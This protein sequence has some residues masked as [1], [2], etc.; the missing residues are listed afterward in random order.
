MY[1]QSAVKAYQDAGNHAGSAR[2]REAAL[3]IK[4]AANLQKAK[5]EK[6]TRED[7]DYALEFNRKIWTF[8]VG[9]LLD[10]NHE[11]PKEIRE[12]IVNL[13]IFTFNQTVK[14]M[15]EPR[16]DGVDALININRNIAEGLRAKV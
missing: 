2:D 6:S 12:N 10:E 16:N 1:N 15:S 5:S 11:M 9:E 8:F 14:I 4:A 3:F 13:G 7:W